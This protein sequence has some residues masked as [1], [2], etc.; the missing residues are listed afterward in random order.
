M[1]KDD[2]LGLGLKGA[3]HHGLLVAHIDVAV[4][5]LVNAAE[6]LHQGG[7]PGT[8]FPHEGVHLARHHR[9]GHPVQRPHTGEGFD[10]VFKTQNRITHTFSSSLPL[11]LS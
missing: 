3:G 9:K 6:H 5:G 1:D 8:V 2:T 11:T 7:F 10:D 4:I